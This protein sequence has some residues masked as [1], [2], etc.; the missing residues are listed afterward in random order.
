MIRLGWDLLTLSDGLSP[1][2]FMGVSGFG[3]GGLAVALVF[4]ISTGTDAPSSLLSEEAFAVGGV[5]EYPGIGLMWTRCLEYCVPV[6]LSS[7]V[8]DRCPSTETTVPLDHRAFFSWGFFINM[9]VWCCSSLGGSPLFSLSFVL[10]A[11]FTLL[12]PALML[13]VLSNKLS[14][15]EGRSDLTFLWHI[16]S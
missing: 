10:S 14:G 2:C 8:Y 11:C 13:L 1:F 15:I 4:G 16:S 5:G 6:A 9:T 3:F 12:W 7:T